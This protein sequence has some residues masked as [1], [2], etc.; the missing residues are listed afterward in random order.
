MLELTEAFVNESG[1]KLLVVLSY[2]QGGV[3]RALQDEPNWDQS[4]VD[5]LKTRDYPF[6]DLRQHH[7]AEFNLFNLDP[8]AYLTRY[9]NGPQR[10]YCRLA[11]PQALALQLNTAPVHRIGAMPP[12]A[13]PSAG[14]PP[15]PKSTGSTRAIP[16]PSSSLRAFACL[17]I[18]DL[19]KKIYVYQVVMLLSFFYLLL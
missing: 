13:T 16:T 1:K 8:A 18:A 9:Y 10:L 12:L 3:L 19:C 6:L 2:S 14:P 17:R 15:T 11:R 4:T 7:L 5:F